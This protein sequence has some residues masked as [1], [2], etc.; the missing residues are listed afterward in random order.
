[1]NGINLNI[2]N[3]RHQPLSILYK[4]KV[5]PLYTL[6]C[7]EQSWIINYASKMSLI[8]SNYDRDVYHYEFPQFHWQRHLQYFYQYHHHCE[9]SRFLLVEGIKYFV[10]LLSHSTYVTSISDTSTMDLCRTSAN[11]YHFLFWR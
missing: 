10:C 9:S 6:S 5:L 11:F 1:V 7:L 3:R 8:P 4:I 2:I